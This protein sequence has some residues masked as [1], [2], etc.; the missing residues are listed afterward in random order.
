MDYSALGSYGRPFGEA[1]RL[2]LV[3]WHPMLVLVYLFFSELL[4]PTF[5]NEF[6]EAAAAT[7]IYVA[8]QPPCLRGFTSR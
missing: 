8:V 7:A 1:F 3:E 6:G 5:E 4:V 2:L